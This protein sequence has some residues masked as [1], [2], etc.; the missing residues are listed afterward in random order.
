MNDTTLTSPNPDKDPQDHGIPEEGAELSE[1]Q[2]VEILN[3]YRLEAENSRE[4]SRGQRDRT[5][6][7]NIDL[8]WNRFDFSQKQNWQANEV[9]PEAPQFVNRFAATM[10]QSLTRDG[11]FFTVE[12]PA[13]P[14]GDISGVVK[15]LMNMFLDRCGRNATGHPVE[16][17]SVFEDIMKLAAMMAAC[18]A[19]TYKE[20]DGEGYVAVDV[21]DPREFYLD[22]TGRGLYRFKRTY[23]DLHELDA[24]AQLKNGKDKFIYNVENIEKLQSF[25]STEDK[26]DREKLADHGMEETSTREPIRIDEYLCDL[27]DNQGNIRFTN[28]LFIVA[29]D[30]HLIRGPEKN[31]WWHKRDWVVFAPAISVPLSVYGKTYMEDWSKLARTFNEL[32]NLILDAVHT[33][34][35][36]AFIAKPTALED[37]DQLEE[38]IHPNKIFYAEE[39]EDLKQVIQ[40]LELGK[41][42]PEAIT[43]WQAIKKELQ[44]GALFSEIALGQLSRGE[45]TATEISESQQGSA[46]TLQSIAK[47]IE[48]NHLEPTFQLIWMTGLQHLHKMKDQVI[49][50][51]GEPAYEMLIARR[52]DFIKDKITFKVDAISGLIDRNEKFKKLMSLLQII[53]SNELLLK[54]F[55]EQT[56]ASVLLRKIFQLNGLD[57]KELQPTERQGQVAG[58]VDQSGRANE[59]AQENLANAQPAPSGDQVLANVAQALP[60]QVTG[61]GN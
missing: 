8:Y 30:Q 7:D 37:P 29:N 48:T 1:L 57:L 40:A 56:D 32:T 28:Y 54:T 13:D 15:K 9:L 31:P 4:L 19:V 36:N 55:M 42:P 39:D 51:V 25:G 27:V 12:H 58:I 23:M 5:W 45:K 21:V 26:E 60:P 46:T 53:S 61:N 10:R 14:N 17:G 24:L 22:P 11:E 41:L 2:I 38:G 20:R 33:N 44:E 59:A 3:G 18:S 43:M 16:F 6:E 49:A 47:N 34:S 35:M 50:A 52:K